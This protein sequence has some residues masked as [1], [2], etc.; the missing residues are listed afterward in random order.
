MNK[1]I[2]RLK[3]KNLIRVIDTPLDVELEIPHVAYIE[4]KKPNPK[5]LLLTHPK[6]GASERDSPVKINRFG[7]FELTRELLGGDEVIAREITSLLTMRPPKG[8]MEK[9]KTLLKPP[10][11]KQRL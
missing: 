8:L 5:A 4:A 1:L 7:S 2:D 10:K 11:A 3:E 9:I 6:D